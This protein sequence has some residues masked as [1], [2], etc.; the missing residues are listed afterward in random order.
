MTVREASKWARSARA[1]LI[2]MGK[3]TIYSIAAI[4]DLERAIRL[5]PS[6]RKARIDEF[7]FNVGKCSSEIG[8][9]VCL[10]CISVLQL[11]ETSS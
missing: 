1:A 9:R 8:E 5:S 6:R 2:A 10:F 3:P 4:D 7:K 11:L